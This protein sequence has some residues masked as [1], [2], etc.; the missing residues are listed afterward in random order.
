MGCC[1]GEQATG[2]AA[3]GALAHGGRRRSRGGGDDDDGETVVVV[4]LTGPVPG[5]VVLA[6][7][8]KRRV[9]GASERQQQQRQR[10]SV[11]A[12][13][14][15]GYWR[16][17]GQAD[18]RTVRQTYR[19]TDR[20]ETE[21]E[22]PPGQTQTQRRTGV[23]PRRRWAEDGRLEGLWRPD[24]DKA[25]AGRMGVA[26]SNLLPPHVADAA[27]GCGQWCVG[28]IGGVLG[29]RLLRRCAARRHRESGTAALPVTQTLALALATLSCPAL[30]LSRPGCFQVC[31]A[32][33]PP[34]CARV[35]G[36]CEIAVSP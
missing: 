1:C 28:G 32:S 4:L 12:A 13:A 18:R 23:V 3:R 25:R 14:V 16:W 31:K 27:V 17:D 9:V 30:P 34:A 10:E 35:C 5:L 11:C 19:Q 24:S 33:S 22:I 2:R 6:A 36:V 26:R 20:H 29:P 21:R 8:V 7:R 15:V